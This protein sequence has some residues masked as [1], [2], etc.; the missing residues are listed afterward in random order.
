MNRHGTD[1]QRIRIDMRF[2]YDRCEIHLQRYDIHVE[3]AQVAALAAALRHANNRRGQQKHIRGHTNLV[4]LRARTSE[5]LGVLARPR[6]AGWQRQ[7]ERTL[8]MPVT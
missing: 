4:G 5:G 6:C 3:A 8:P 7:P 1:I 2:T